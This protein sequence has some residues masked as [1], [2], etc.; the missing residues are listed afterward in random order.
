MNSVAIERGTQVKT[1][2][3]LNMRFSKIR[4]SL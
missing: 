3:M 4:K 2:A 1:G